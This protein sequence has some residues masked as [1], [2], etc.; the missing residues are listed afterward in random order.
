MSAC[1]GCELDRHCREYHRPGERPDLYEF[2]AQ[3]VPHTGLSDL[4][5][6]AELTRRLS[7]EMCG[8]GEAYVGG[9]TVQTRAGRIT[10]TCHGERLANW[11]TR[12]VADAF[13]DTT[14]RLL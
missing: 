2:A 10:L 6:P 8:S 14:P 12:Q 1:K 13:L 9:D 11:T 4:T 7:A 5:D 3:W